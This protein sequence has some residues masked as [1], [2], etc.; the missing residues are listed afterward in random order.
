M[1]LL[2]A[3]LLLLVV[4]A[5]ICPTNAQDTLYVVVGG[6]STT[7]TSLD[8]A[9]GSIQAAVDV[10]SEGATISIGSGTFVE[11]IRIMTA[12]LTLESEDEENQ[13]TI[14]SAGGVPD[15]QA[16]ADVPVDVVV[17]LLAP[18]ITLENLSI[19]HPMGPATKRDVGVFVRPPAVNATLS[20]LVV[21]RYR[22]GE[23]LE[24]FAPGSRGLLV[25]RATGVVCE[26]STFRG[27]YQDHIHLPTS[28]SHIEDNI[29][30]NATRLGIVIIQETPDSLS[31]DNVIKENTVSGI[32]GDGIQIQGDRNSFIDNTVFGCAGYGIHLCGANSNPPCVPPGQM[33]NA[34]QNQLSGNFLWNNDLGL[35]EPA[36]FGVENYIGPSHE[37]TNVAGTEAANNDLETTTMETHND[38]GH[39][40]NNTMDG[41]DKNNNT[42]GEDHDPEDNGEEDSSTSTT[43]DAAT[44]TSGAMRR[45]SDV[46]SFVSHMAFALIAAVA[47]LCL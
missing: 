11:N 5:L 21:E 14:E 33:A 20:N 46:D 45:L 42:M 8:D 10:A 6:T 43:T 40:N 3:L 18:N 35:G 31:I 2:S 41:G 9:C 15:Q 12:G 36:D 27:N 24:P 26:D 13:A 32:A 47:V 34:S 30:A 39:N 7:C 16:P 37:F 22:T 23:P 44:N 28:E 25:F 19:R 38:N 17:D 29:V 4:L 1:K